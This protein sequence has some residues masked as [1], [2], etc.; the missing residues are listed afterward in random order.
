MQNWSFAPIFESPFLVVGI[1]VALLGLISLIRPYRTLTSVRRRWLVGLRALVI[2]ILGIVMLRPGRTVTEV[3]TRQATVIVLT[4]ETESMLQPAA[5]DDLSRWEHQQQTWQQTS[6]FLRNQSEQ[7]SPRWF[8][9]T[10]RLSQQ[11]WGEAESEG[12]LQQPKGKF[13]DLGTALHQAVS[14]EPGQQIHAV[15]L[16]GDGR[17][18]AYR[19]EVDIRQAMDELRRRGIPLIGVPFGREGDVLDSKDVAI[20]QLPQQ[21][22]VFSGN[23]I[24]INAIAKLRGLLGQPKQV[25]LKLTPSDGPTQVIQTLEVTATEA[26]DIQPVQFTFTA[27]SP[28]TYLLEVSAET[29]EGELLL[30][31][32]RQTAYLTVL[33]GG[34]R[35]LYL[36]GNRLGE[37]L[38]M[39]R[40]L[41][42]S[43]DIELTESYIRHLSADDWPDPRA[44]VLIDQEYDVLIL[45]D[46]H[47]DAIGEENLTAVA[48]AVA[49]GKGIMMVGGF[50]SFGPGA[51]R[52]SPLEP[53]LPIEM[54][55]FE[56]QEVGA[57]LPVR[58][59]FHLDRE[60][61]M[62]VTKPH[63]LNQ[64]ES[65]GQIWNQLPALQGANL[66]QGVKASGEVIL[67][68]EQNEPLMVTSQHG[69][70]RV[71]AFAGDS[72]W[73]W[74]RLGFAD[75][76]RRFWRQNI[77]WLARRENLQQR[78][79]WLQLD[80][81]R[82][83][84]EAE[85][86]FQ[87]GVDVL[88]GE[89]LELQK[90][91]WNIALTNKGNES[92]QVP[93]AMR[94]GVWEGMLPVL[95]KPGEY[96]LLAEVTNDGQSIG[97]AMVN[98]QIIDEQP[99]R[100]NPLAD[101]QQFNRLADMT[102]DSGGRVV[103]PDEL[104]KV[105]LNVIEKASEQEVE[106]EMSWQL[107]ATPSS[108]WL[109]LLILSGL[110]SVD[111]MLRK[112]WGMV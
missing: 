23:E 33:E 84:P 21:F 60:I 2:V 45:E 105:L 72:T 52:D 24:E 3:Q 13:T 77:L 1:G 107:G 92:Q 69:L 12:D 19:G 57:D 66:F 78:D 68:S 22:R 112:K 6:V 104:D 4:D 62:Q 36:Y 109:L 103:A 11:R 38:E 74:A 63:P 20:E 65:S 79:V 43:Q 27:D 15:V 80:Q 14:T 73:R 7:V 76:L 83:V 48:E 58:R 16:M 91:K 86:E 100:S 31:N 70:G 99:E 61:S 30:A 46:V 47:A 26:D 42:S 37:Q 41:A 50:Y 101:F 56:R 29:A 49:D 55:L 10:D 87:A 53:V 25:Q 39:R 51:Y 85:I 54:E 111:W 110:F 82:F 102:A 98:F 40:S 88:G 106:I 75:S 90:L 44:N 81:R 17:Q 64:L 108:A 34:L 18:T 97:K 32:N 35:V 71:V 8:G 96:Q 67:S 59:I 95:P 5:K 93:I 89:L 9:Y 28:G 94:G